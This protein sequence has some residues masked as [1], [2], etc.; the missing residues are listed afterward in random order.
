MTDERDVKREQDEGAEQP[1]GESEELKDLEA[2][3][4]GEDVRGG[5]TS[6]KAGKEQQEYL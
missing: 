2:D 1:E 6:R 3:R 4:E 5:L